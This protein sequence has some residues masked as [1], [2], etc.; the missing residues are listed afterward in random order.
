MFTIVVEIKNNCLWFHH[1]LRILIDFSID[2]CIDLLQTNS[3][4]YREEDNKQDDIMNY[5]SMFQ[6]MKTRPFFNNCTV[7]TAG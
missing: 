7:N 2:V 5:T 1:A 4:E 6:Y 3:W